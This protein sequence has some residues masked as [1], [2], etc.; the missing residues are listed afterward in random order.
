VGRERDVVGDQAE[1]I[2]LPGVRAAASRLEAIQQ[3][4]GNARMARLLASPGGARAL[5]GLTS[6][7]ALAR[8]PWTKKP[9]LLPDEPVEIKR[10][11]ELDPKMFIRKAEAHAERE[12]EGEHPP[13]PQKFEPGD[14]VWYYAHPDPEVPRITADFDVPRDLW[15]PGSTGTT[16]YKGHGMEICEY[17]IYETAVKEGRPHMRG[18]PGSQA[19]INNN[20]GNL[21]GS[22]VD[23]GQYRGK[24][25]WHGF[26][27]FPTYQAGYDAIPKWLEAYGYYSKG[28]LDAME[29]YAPAADGNDPV[30]YANGIVSALK[31]ETTADGAAITLGTTL[32][33]LSEAQMRKVQDAIV[34]A[35][36]TI[37]GVTHTRD[38]VNLPV[39]IRR[40][41]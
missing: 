19:W 10:D 13:T 27:I 8:Y 22:K 31:G 9:E 28:I 11:F 21:T 34:K 26:L 33:K 17:V 16:D 30:G 37:E 4:V 2:A 5:Q 6:R 36:G 32:E 41:L 3:A 15:F 20:P 12:R 35:E 7:Q 40:R 14:H 18:K 29:S 39:E 25:N 1:E 24:V 38:D 23:I